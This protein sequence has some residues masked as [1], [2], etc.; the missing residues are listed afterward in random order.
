MAIGEGFASR[1]WDRVASKRVATGALPALRHLE[2]LKSA[3]GGVSA[4]RKVELLRV[5]A[6]GRLP[7]AKQVQR[8]HE[9]LCFLRGYPD[10]PVLLR[11]VERM[12]EGFA[13]RSD[14]R[15]HRAV[16]ADS[17]IAGTAIHYQ[18]FWFTAR[19]LARRWPDRLEIDWA[20]FENRAQLV[21]LL[22]LLVPYC[23]S[24]A[25]EE[26]EFSAREWIERLRGPR[27]TDAAF[28]V[29][30]FDAM[31][32]DSF[33][34]ETHYER[35]DPPLRLR[36]GPGTPS[37]TLAKYGGVRVVFRTRPLARTR[38]DLRREIARPP[39]VVR[40]VTRREG[41][42]LLDLAREAMVT[43]SR[44]LDSFETG[45]PNDVRLVDCG[46]GLQF[47]CIGAVP[48]RRA[49]LDTVY[50]FLT[51]Q[52]GVPAGY[53]LSSALFGS[54]G[55]AY[56]I[57]ETFRGGESAYVYGRALAMV[58]H[59][60][61]CDAFSVDPYQ[62]GHHNPEGLQSGAWWFY[63]KLGFRPH[64]AAVRRVLRQELALMRR[65]PSHHSSV[66]TLRRLSAKPVFLYVGRPRADVVG[67]LQLGNVSLRVA[68]FL[69]ARFGAEREA[70]IRVCSR[71]AMRLLGVRSR[72][73]FTPGERLAWEHWSPLAMTIPGI[74]GWSPSEK[75]D[76]VHVVRAKGGR[77][78]SDYV[79]LFD[80]HRCLRGAVLKLARP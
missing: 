56:N 66:A 5:L 48:E 17:G 57:F 43:R 72:N 40:P 30:R 8:L 76:L 9:S 16:L 64:D 4:T 67:R 46:D 53:V 7:S 47:A 54:A 55:V 11:Q 50:G 39:L 33:G 15:R 26:R 21:P 12:L 71:E 74:E 79:P 61:G 58:R 35:L 14:L 18:F 51:L 70:G 2:R 49:L 28:L 29:R 77:R 63:Y 44:D 20:A 10:D 36:P 80:A 31:R 60:F 3:Y 75:R 25:L 41:S 65:D 34:R 23:E 37:R 22:R 1:G 24:G 27:E 73:G 62:L 13:A 42:K 6:R 19:W 59:L 52:N 38:P 32:A 45:D 78:E 68:Q 69:A